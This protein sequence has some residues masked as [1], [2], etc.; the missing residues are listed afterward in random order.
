MDKKVILITGANRGLG[1]HLAKVLAA[2]DSIIILGCRRFESGKEIQKHITYRGGHSQIVQLDLRD[3]QDLVRLEQVLDQIGYLDILIN[4]S[5]VFSDVYDSTI[6]S[7][8][9]DI[10]LEMV[11]VNM[12]APLQLTKLCLS[13]LLKRKE[14]AV[15]NV[16]SDLADYHAPDGENTLYRM[17]KSALLAMTVNLAYEFKDTGLKAFAIDPGWMKT[18]MGGDDAPDSPEEI[19]ESV[20]YMIEDRGQCISGCVYYK[21]I[22]SEWWNKNA[23]YG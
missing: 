6:Q 17:T 22:I 5:G 11:Q 16:I 15:F 4:N 3:K 13:F 7:I 9:D 18:D 10:I 2:P 8:T 23:K 19:A 12:V 20:K 21:G 14:S 1:F